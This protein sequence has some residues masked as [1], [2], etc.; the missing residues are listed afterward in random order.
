[1]AKK[2]TGNL[3]TY[4]GP[5]TEVVLRDPE[6]GSRLIAQR[7]GEPIEVSDEVA[8]GLREQWQAWRDHNPPTTD[9]P[10]ADAAPAEEP[11]S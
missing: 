6:T 5:H 3:F 7:D 4:L 8:N 2:K 1:M 10:A 11:A 9:E